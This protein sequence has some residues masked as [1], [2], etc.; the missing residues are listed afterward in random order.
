MIMLLTTSFQSSAQTPEEISR[1]ITEIKNILDKYDDGYDQVFKIIEEE[2]S[3][4]EGDKISNSVWHCCMADF[5]MNYKANNLYKIG[6]ITTL[7]GDKPEDFKEW[8]AKML[9]AEAKKH[10][11]TALQKKDELSAVPASEYSPILFSSIY[12]DKKSVQFK[13]ELDKLTL[14]DVVALH[15]VNFLENEQNELKDSQFDFS[16]C[17]NNESFLKIPL[18]VSV[19]GTRTENI[20]ALYQDMTLFH[21]VRENH[22]IV[23]KLTLSRLEFIASVSTGLDSDTYI[24]I[25]TE[26][27]DA[28]PKGTASCITFKLAEL[29]S[30]RAMDQAMATNHVQSNDLVKAVELYMEIVAGG[31]TEFLSAAKEN[32]K[33]IQTPKISLET[34]VEPVG[35][36]RE[37]FC[38]L[39]HKN[40]SKATLKVIKVPASMERTVSE[41]PYQARKNLQA[42]LASNPVYEKQLT[43]ENNHD[44]AT[45][46]T[47]E[48]LPGLGGGTYM[49]VVSKQ[50]DLQSD[51]NPCYSVFQVTDIHLSYRVEMDNVVRFMAVNRVTGEPI[52]NARISLKNR[53]A[54]ATLS[55]GKDGM[56]AFKLSKGHNTA[57]AVSVKWNGQVLYCRDFHSYVQEN[58]INKSEV[59]R[60][61]TDRSLYRP[62]QTVHFKGLMI[63]N[64]SDNA[65][66]AYTRM[67]PGKV[68]EVELYD[69]NHQVVRRDTFT[70]NEYGSFSGGFELPL[71]GITGIFSVTVNGRHVHGFNVEEYKRPSFE[72]RI[73]S[74]EGKCELGGKV[75]VNGVAEAFAG[76]PIAGAGVKYTVRRRICRAWWDRYNIDDR[77]V[78]AGETATDEDGNFSISFVA[79]SLSGKDRNKI[80][81]FEIEASVTDINGETRQA[82]SSIRLSE[83]SLL[84]NCII[85]SEIE[86]KSSDN[87][88]EVSLLNLYGKRQSGVV[89][90]EILKLKTP[91]RFL[92]GIPVGSC[93]KA[94]DELRQKFPYIAFEG[95][96]E[97]EKWE[98]SSVAKGELPVEKDGTTFFALHSLEKMESGYYKI[99]F[100]ATDSSGKV[101]EESVITH[102]YSKNDRECSGYDALWVNVPGSVRAGGKVGVELG[103][104]LEK[105]SVFCE[106][107]LNDSVLV[108]RWFELEKGMVELPVSVDE[109]A[110]GQLHVHLY[111]IN[112]NIETTIV[113]DID[114]VNVSKDIS[115]EFLRF[116]DETLPGGREEWQIRLKDSDG[117]PLSAEVLCS[118]YDCSLDAIGG[119]NV[120]RLGFAPTFN[121]RPLNFQKLFQRSLYTGDYLPEFYHSQ[122][123]IYRAPYF[124]FF[125]EA[126]RYNR[127]FMSKAAVSAAES[128]EV[129][130]GNRDDLFA[131]AAVADIVEYDNQEESAVQ[132]SAGTN[133]YQ[134]MSVDEGSALQVR[135]N[136]DETAFFFPELRTDEKG[137]IFFSFTMP[138]ALTMWKF[139]GVAHTKKLH[140]GVFAK[141]VRARK[142]MMV[143][144]NM[145]RFFREGDEMTLSA[146]VVNMSDVDLCGHVT[147]SFR[148]AVSGNPVELTDGSNTVQYDVKAGAS[149]EVGFSIAIP[150]G[151]QALVC[152][153]VAH[154]TGPDGFSGDGEERVVPV[155]PN[156]ALVTEAMP[157]SISGKGHKI[158][159]F[160]R[161]KESFTPGWSTTSENYSL[162]VECTPNPLWYAIQALPYMM[163]Y[164][165]ECNEQKF[166]RYYANALA[167]HIL[168]SNP[169]IEAIFNKAQ[170]DSPESFVSALEKNQELKQ[171]VLEE[172]PWLVDAQRESS[173]MKNM[174]ILFDFKKMEKE[175]VTT[176]N[177]LKKSQNSDGGWSWFAGGRSS[178]FIT[179]HILAGFGHLAA[180]GVAMPSSKNFL[181]RG[182]AYIDRQ[183]YERYKERK[184]QKS[185]PVAETHYLYARSFF[186]SRIPDEYRKAY[187]ETYSAMIA[188]WSKE[189]F[190]MQAMIALAAWRNGD[191]SV[192]AQIVAHLKSMA[193][194]D[195]ENGMFWKRQGAGLFWHE[196][197]IERQAL[198]IEAFNTITP[199]D[200]ESISKMQLWLLKQKQSQHWGSTKSTT[201][202]VYALLTSR[203]VLE[204]TQ[205]KLKIG[206]ET[207]PS[208]AMK[209]A[210]GSGYFKTSWKGGDI[211]KEMSEVRLEKNDEGP[212]WGAL[213]WKYFEDYDKIS[214]SEDMNLGV[215]K[216]LFVVENDGEGEVLRNVA[217]GNTLHV[218][219]KVRVRII[220]SADRD[221][222]YVHL[223]DQRAACFEPLNVLSQY[224]FQGGLFYYESTRDASTDFFID[225]LPKGKHVF[226]YTLYATQKGDFSSGI[227][228][229]ECMYAPEFQSHTKGF[230]VEV[231]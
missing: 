197:P 67:L 5:F 154:N 66:S 172:T 217:A 103:S 178:D 230:R 118:M 221:M 61:F 177:R 65:G 216:E 76:Y 10:L 68:V 207:L 80:H 185:E 175:S 99:V 162:T 180:L 74:P 222:E 231:K 22:A 152:R 30:A 218:G 38:I 130:M 40:I 147:L 4:S 149:Q 195:E 227:T 45:H 169:S 60:F 129:V 200:N 188:G 164:P 194:E 90:Y 46:T 6:N 17:W 15:A 110:N 13:R 39:K 228:H 3:R 215:G 51:P 151:V 173:S 209:A 102:V 146:K 156:R 201:E 183:M 192:A 136:F 62:G 35:V 98:A 31:D 41:N 94:S 132:T 115:F 21:S 104:Y 219:D 12:P 127:V 116:R 157:F 96:N 208:E 166:S 213:Y 128:G 64:V 214:G 120:Y 59:C 133:A 108:S 93:P 28:F 1:K 78:A 125:P 106:I 165:Y 186:N 42:L 81:I 85:D 24:D 193:Q 187:D 2:I 135:S 53:G 48:I 224:K 145:P 163:E 92:H 8:N 123:Y 16:P 75:T 87:L 105:A 223:K 211:A 91:G 138:D 11:F 160:K 206:G 14:Y 113:R 27:R 196:Q 56:A 199:D 124:R 23:A 70:T 58:N 134:E 140:S 174:A 25:L 141:L 34:F 121:V 63:E 20:L 171:L 131:E 167:T 202:A 47:F 158:F 55:T 9:T 69:A 44:Y 72:V 49:L 112:N 88:F 36:G 89:E 144:P 107:S 32:L 77:I 57:D 212:A 18:K 229:V 82:I 220:L 153:I 142:D 97:K 155:L 37:S 179:T 43:L 52:N 225:Y 198:L 143:V 148:D 191:K 126:W 205:V 139:Q 182:V 159:T 100:R 114:I 117:R 26:C 119:S 210:T 83:K 161:L 189:S 204:S 111:T 176:I 33:T 170:A 29:H 184:R 137:D 71:G 19:D 95:E 226:E 122:R 168:K 150:K 54:A 84:I 86:K 109:N 50:K 79:E 190:Y 181:D 203:I 7:G 73:D 101:V